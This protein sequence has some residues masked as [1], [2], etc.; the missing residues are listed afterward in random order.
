MRPPGSYRWVVS[1]AAWACA[2]TIVAVQASSGPARAG[3]SEVRPMSHDEALKRI[4]EVA[5]SSRIARY[6]WSGR[7][8][9]PA[10]YLKGMAVV[11]A[12]ACCK[13]KDGDRYTREMAKASTGNA[14]KDALAHYQA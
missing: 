12:R 1:G 8:V 6:S 11:Y 4:T 3:S 2:A 5:A 14:T 10:G 9:A 7:G 13:L